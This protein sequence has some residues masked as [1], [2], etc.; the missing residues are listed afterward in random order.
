MTTTTTTTAPTTRASSW[1]SRV[2]G[3]I[4]SPRQGFTAL[5]DDDRA[6]L[7]E[8][9][10]IYAVVVFSIAGAEVYR[11]LALAS[12]A[13]LIVMSRLLDVLLRAA[14]ATLRQAAA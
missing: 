5:I 6:H 3:I 12:V 10:L 1:W 7:V 8:P 11:L 13:P 2:G 4:A 9:L 14:Q